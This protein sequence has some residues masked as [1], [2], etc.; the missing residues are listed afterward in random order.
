MEGPMTFEKELDEVEDN[1]TTVG[2][3][4]PIIKGIRRG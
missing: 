4:A 2:T 1:A 3:E